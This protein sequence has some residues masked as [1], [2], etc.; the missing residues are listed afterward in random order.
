MKKTQEQKNEAGAEQT[1]TKTQ[2]Q[3]EFFMEG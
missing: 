2:M 3:Y 1:E